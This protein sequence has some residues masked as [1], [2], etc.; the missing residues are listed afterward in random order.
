MQHNKLLQL[1]RTIDTK[2]KEHNTFKGPPLS[3]GTAAAKL[4]IALARGLCGY[5][6]ITTCAYVRSNVLPFCRF[7]TSELE[8]GPDGIKRN[9]GLPKISSTEIFLIEQ[10]IPIINEFVNMAVTAARSER[11]QARIR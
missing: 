7:F 9:L 6:N 2:A 4:I 10:I 8:L 1:F 5:D 11:V 3:H